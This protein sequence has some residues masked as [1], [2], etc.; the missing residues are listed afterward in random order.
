MRLLAI[1]ELTRPHNCALAGLAVVIG[2]IISLGG[3]PDPM[4][5][6]LAFVVAAIICGGGNAINDYFDREIDAINRPSRPIP[7]QRIGLHQAQVISLGLFFAGIFISLL[8]N[9]ACFLLAVFNSIV[10]FLYS[11][12]IKRLGLAG[13][14]TIGYLVGSTFLFGGLA[15]GSMEN[16]SIFALMAGLSTV[17]RELIKDIE[18]MEGDKKL[19]IVTFPLS[20]SARAA[21]GLATLFVVGAIILSPLPYLLGHFGVVYL[22]F[23]FI[24]VAI[25]VRAA[26]RILRE[27]KVNAASRA[28]FEF[29]VAM[30]IGLMAFLIGA[31]I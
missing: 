2:S 3:I 21:A 9:E 10:L 11:A 14:L 12:K 4:K 25:F 27:S 15:A 8:I 31:F 30:G 24:S 20:H 28:S 26:A 1:F 23:V 5:V 16:V 19:G 18:D 22:I 6:M 13:N 7:S 17:A 29:K